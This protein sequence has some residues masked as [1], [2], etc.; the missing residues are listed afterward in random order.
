MLIIPNVIT[1]PAFLLGM[2]FGAVQT[3][4]PAIESPPFVRDIYGSLIGV[5][6]GAGMLLV[7]SLLYTYVRKKQGLGLGDVKLLAVTGA[8]F[9][10]HGA[11]YTIFV[12]S[13]LGSLLGVTLMLIGR[14]KW[15]SYIPFGPYLAAANLLYIYFAQELALL[16]SQAAL[17]QQ[18]YQ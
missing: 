2:I 8:F 12:G 4:Y 13:L 11:F 18:G 14:G 15:S 6:G 10:F 17:Q 1:Y 7:V 3:F 16:L 5:L 9:G